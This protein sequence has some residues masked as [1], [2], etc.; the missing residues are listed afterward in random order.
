[1]VYSQAERVFV[2]EHYLA[3]ES[4]AAVREAFKNMYPSKEVPNKIIKDW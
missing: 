4:F 3:S 2:L 1:M